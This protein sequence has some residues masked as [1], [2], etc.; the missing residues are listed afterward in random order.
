[1]VGNRHDKKIVVLKVQTISWIQT[2]TVSRI[3][4]FK[5]FFMLSLRALAN[6]FVW[7]CQQ[8][9][10]LGHVTQIDITGGVR[11]K[12]IQLLYIKCIR[13]SRKNL[14]SLPTS[15]LFVPRHMLHL[16]RFITLD[17]GLLGPKALFIFMG[18][19]FSRDEVKSLLYSWIES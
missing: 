8:Q 15:L 1:M 16:K 17:T 7:N 18:L 4:F 13:Q 5:V 19:C 10:T 14:A 2:E 6:L 11:E 12:Y 3:L 9:P